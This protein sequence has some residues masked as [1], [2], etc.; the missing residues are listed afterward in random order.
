MK[1]K[2]IKDRIK[3]ISPITNRITVIKTQKVKYFHFLFSSN[4]IF[5]SA[6]AK[7]DIPNDP[8]RKKVVQSKGP[9]NMWF[10]GRGKKPATIDVTNTIVAVQSVV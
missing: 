10:R 3:L 2:G 4:Q 6:Y 1:S 9:M 8:K 5:N 7:I